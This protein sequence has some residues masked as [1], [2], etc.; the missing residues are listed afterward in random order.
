MTLISVNLL[1]VKS[2]SHSPPLLFKGLMLMASR[3][4]SMETVFAFLGFADFPEL[5][6]LLFLMFLMMYIIT[7]IGNL[8]LIVII[9]IYPKF[10]ILVYSFL[11]HLSLVD[12]CYSPIVTTKMLENLVMAGK[13]IFDSSFML[14]YF[15]S[16]TAVVT[17]S[18]LLQWWPMTT[19]WPLVIPCFTQWSCHRGSVPWWLG[20]T[21]G[22][23]WHPDTPLLC[24]P[25]KL[26]LT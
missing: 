16:C 2:S 5:Q 9:K 10:H 22:Y 4:L 26:F 19:L 13:G 21:S 17:G 8:G 20:H 1:I 23:A 3:N 25:T 11:S 12:F 7:L 15:L 14:Q 6:I 24:S 18:F